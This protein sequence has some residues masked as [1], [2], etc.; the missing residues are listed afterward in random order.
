MNVIEQRAWPT[1]AHPLP[2]V[3]QW[4]ESQH[5]LED[6]FARPPREFSLLP[7]WFWNDALDEK[8]IVRQ[9]D[10]F[11]AHGVFGFVIHPRVGL[12]R[13]IGWMSE[14]MLHYVRFAVEE[15][16]KR[17]MQVVLYDEGM[18]PSGSSCGQVV[19]ENP[20]FACRGLELVCAQSP[21]V[22]QTDH[23]VV[24]NFMRADGTSWHIIDRPVHSVIRGLHFIDEDNQPRHRGGG[25]PP[26]DTPPAADLLNSE[27]M[28]CFVRLVYD[29]YYEALKDYFGT[30]VIGMFTDEPMLLG[31]LCEKAA[32]V[33]GTRG[34]VGW[35]SEWLGYDFEP[36]LPSLWFDDEPEALFHRANYHRALR[37]RLTETYY[38]PLY[39]WCETH[40]VALMG[41]PAEPN[42]IGLERFFHVPGQDIVWRYIEPGKASALEGEQSTQAKCTSSAMIHHGRRRN[43][44]ECYGAYGHELTFDEMQWLAN[45]LFVRGVNMLLPHAFYYSV[46]GPRLDE[47]PPDVGPN[48]PWWSEFAPF[49][50]YCQRLSWL[51]SDSTHRCEIAILADSDVLP[52]NAAKT[53]FEHQL[54]FNYLEVCDLK[55]SEVSEQGIRI[56]GM[57]YKALVV[58]GLSDFEPEV[59]ALLDVLARSGRL[60]D[61]HSAGASLIEHLGRLVAPAFRCVPH[62]SGLRL[63]HV[64]KSNREFCLLCN[65]GET[66]ARFSIE[67]ELAALEQWHIDSGHV[68][69]LHSLEITL[70]TGQSLL[71]CA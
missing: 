40:G 12:P 13:E 4:D 16:A 53:C 45:W 48:S 58:D 46:R 20:D 47:R 39:Q 34:I 38:R 26:E 71:L 42:E 36:Y 15:A 24:A 57:H 44:N 25:D 56:A 61:A 27:A 33:P 35:V 29:R 17:Q 11:L 22:A 10:D 68:T 1:Q 31:R 41:H 43:S 3:L 59:Q 70:D 55:N 8:E 64:S 65:E 14:A 19:A 66:A 51:N 54:D 69:P 2:P 60:I 6:E 32:L 23:H 62:H 63:R 9:L 18:Y 67:T 21:L 49:A 50:L 30:T 28:Q 5:R 37:Q 52:W 7:F